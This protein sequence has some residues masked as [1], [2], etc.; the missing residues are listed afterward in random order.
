MTA[1]ERN[2]VLLAES[3]LS[4]RTCFWGLKITRFDGF[5]SVLSVLYHIL[6]DICL[7]VVISYQ[8]SILIRRIVEAAPSPHYGTAPKKIISTAFE[9]MPL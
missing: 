9:A 8:T 3:F 7:R 1:I 2:R 6:Y 4:E 5:L